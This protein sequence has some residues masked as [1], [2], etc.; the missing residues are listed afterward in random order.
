MCRP[1]RSASTPIRNRHR[2]PGGDYGTSNS[3]GLLLPKRT[4][5]F[6]EDRDFKAEASNAFNPARTVASDRRLCQRRRSCRV[7]SPIAQHVWVAQAVWNPP[8]IGTMA[9]QVLVAL[10]AISATL[11]N[12]SKKR[13]FK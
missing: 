6:S 8:A 9:I 2:C 13:D 1:E 11:I 10:S 4:D 3:R 5:V 7:L 12:Q